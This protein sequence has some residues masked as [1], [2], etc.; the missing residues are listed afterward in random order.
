MEN[1]HSRNIHFSS[2]ESK[3]RKRE[4]REGFKKI[5]TKA[6]NIREFLAQGKEAISFEIRPKGELFVHRVSNSKR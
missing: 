5:R 4:T 1:V 3:K 2:E 6:S